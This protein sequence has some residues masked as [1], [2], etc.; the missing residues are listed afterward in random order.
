MNIATFFYDNDSIDQLAQWNEI[1][2]E[3]SIH[4]NSRLGHGYQS[5]TMNSV[6]I[7]HN[8]EDYLSHLKHYK[9]SS[10][11]PLISVVDDK[12]SHDYHGADMFQRF[13]TLELKR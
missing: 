6:N 10:T 12:S 3:N 1:K 8:Q 4:H 11:V 9:F 5:L 7:S 13:K 2:Y